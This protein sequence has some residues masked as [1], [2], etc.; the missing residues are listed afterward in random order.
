MSINTQAIITAYMAL[1]NIS[2]PIIGSTWL[3]C[4]AESAARTKAAPSAL[5]SLL[6]FLV[7]K[8]GLN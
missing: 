1:S 5:R 7:N 8:T 2:L 4:N 6:F 3:I